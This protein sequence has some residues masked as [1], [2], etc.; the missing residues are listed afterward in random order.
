MSCE[1]PPVCMS[2]IVMVCIR[3]TYNIVYCNLHRS[4]HSSFSGSRCSDIHPCTNAGCCMILKLARY[5]IDNLQGNL[6][7]QAARVR[8]RYLWSNISLL[9]CLPKICLLTE[10]VIALLQI[11]GEDIGQK[12][13]LSPSAAR[14]LQF[15]MQLRVLDH[16]G[17]V[18][19]VLR[20]LCGK[21]GIGW[22]QSE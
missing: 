10:L 9:G 3:H 13:L 20:N 2:W 19:P 21:M 1:R 5:L 18:T 22:E 4:C 14:L 11:A 17:G 8:L 7:R 6:E 12:M 16:S 15:R